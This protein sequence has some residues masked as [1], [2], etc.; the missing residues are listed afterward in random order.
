MKDIYSQYHDLNDPN[1]RPRPK[2]QPIKS[3]KWLI[4]PIPWIL[5]AVYLW[6]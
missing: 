1:D 4:A 2:P 3:W 5:L 6:G